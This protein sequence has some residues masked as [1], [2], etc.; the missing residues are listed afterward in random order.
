MSRLGTQKI[1]GEGHMSAQPARLYMEPTL[2]LNLLGASGWET[3]GNK[4]ENCAAGAQK[5][6]KRHLAKL[7]QGDFP[8]FHVPLAH[9]DRGSAEP[10]VHLVALEAHYAHSTEFHLPMILGILDHVQPLSAGQRVVLGDGLGSAL[11]PDVDPTVRVIFDTYDGTLSSGVES[12]AG[13]YRFQDIP[14][15]MAWRRVSLVHEPVPHQV[16]EAE[17]LVAVPVVQL[18]GAADVNICKNARWG[19][20]FTRTKAH[21]KVPTATPSARAWGTS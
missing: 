15:H 17:Q 18:E 21:L 9:T 12:K 5:G 7:V 2:R 16:Y 19:R 8:E 10:T 11:H 6:L 13:S 4:P 3:G 14:R 20:A 1:C